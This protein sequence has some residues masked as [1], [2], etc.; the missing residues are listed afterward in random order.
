MNRI[1][2]EFRRDD[3]RV[4]DRLVDG[5]LTEADRKQLLMALDD[6]PGAWRRCALAFLESQAWRG[7]FTAARSE[8]APTAS[9]AESSVVLPAK[10]SRFFETCLAIAASVMVAFGLGAWIR[11]EWQTSDTPSQFAG[12]NA[13]HA[14]PAATVVGHQAPWHRAKVNFNDAGASGVRELEVPIVEAP[15]VSAEWLNH[16][17]SAMPADVE[18]ELKRSGHRITKHRALVPVQADDGR[19]LLMPVEQVDVEPQPRAAY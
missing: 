3:E 16:H 7:D 1:I 10:P 19:M 11:G 4:L 18:Q 13:S 9:P 12:H 14:L 8:P 6:E 5:E 2:D 17:A 15:S